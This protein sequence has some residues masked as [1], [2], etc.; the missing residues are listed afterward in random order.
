MYLQKGRLPSTTK[1]YLEWMQ[2]QYWML[3]F[4]TPAKCLM[5]FP[6]VFTRQNVKLQIRCFACEMGVN[7]YMIW[8]MEIK[9]PSAS[10]LMT[11][12]RVLGSTHLKDELSYRQ[13]KMSR[14]RGLSKTIRSLAMTSEE[15]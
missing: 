8:M 12:K 6:T 15:S 7:L 13:T 5:H 4:W 1:E 10:F 14:K 9:A 11:L 2:G 3:F